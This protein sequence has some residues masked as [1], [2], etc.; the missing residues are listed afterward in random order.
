MPLLDMIL[1]EF[2][3]E[4]ATTR[5]VLDRVADD[6]LHYKPHEKSWTMAELAT[7]LA[8]M[9]KWA[10]STFE[11]DSF[12]YSPGGAPP[13]K[14]VPVQSKQELLATFEELGYEL[15]HFDYD[16]GML[17]RGAEGQTGDNLVAVPKE[18]AS[19]AG[20]EPALSP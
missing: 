6:Q 8:N 19:P 16:T 12:D 10:V 2:D 5:K 20:F 7:H 9:L 17:R 15:Y 13:E 4:M 11:T 1:P 14:E 3:Q 18:M